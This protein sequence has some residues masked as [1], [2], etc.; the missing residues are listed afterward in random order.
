VGVLDLSG[1]E[2]AVTATPSRLVDRDIPL[3]EV[4][5]NSG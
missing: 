4:R 2:S 5:I 1:D 3:E